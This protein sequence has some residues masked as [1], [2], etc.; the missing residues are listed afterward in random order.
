M[1]DLKLR[2]YEALSP[3]ATFTKRTKSVQRTLYHLKNSSAKIVFQPPKEATAGYSLQ[4]TPLL[5]L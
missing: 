3:A 1:Q 5:S 2:G 4:S